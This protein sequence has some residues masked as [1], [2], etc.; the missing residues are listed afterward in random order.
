MRE[1]VQDVQIAALVNAAMLVMEDAIIRAHI[2]L[3]VLAFVVAA[4]EVV[5]DHAMGVLMDVELSVQDVQDVQDVHHLAVDVEVVLLR[6]EASV[7]LG[8]KQDAL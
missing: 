6:V 3:D 5:K 7:I 4:M 1:V 2:A 8:V